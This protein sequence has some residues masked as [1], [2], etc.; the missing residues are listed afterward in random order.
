V[1][2]ADAHRHPDIEP[3][4]DQPPTLHCDPR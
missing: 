1:H 4:L 3:G 2:D